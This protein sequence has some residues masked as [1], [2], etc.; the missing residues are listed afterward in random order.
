MVARGAPFQ[1]TV[2]PLTK[3]APLTVS[4]KAGEPPAIAELGLK[5]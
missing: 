4:V 5:S 2:D 3:P 1:L